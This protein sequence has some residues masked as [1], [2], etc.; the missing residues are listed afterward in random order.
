MVEQG[1]LEITS[2][3][4]VAVARFRSASITDLEEISAVS[5]RIRDFIDKNRP[6]RMVFDFEC[7]KFFSSQV[8]GLI[9]DVRARLKAYSG[10]VVI[11]AIDPQLH[12]VFRITNLDRIL[13]FFPDSESAV[14]SM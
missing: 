5:E 8:L 4:G 12:R 13:K 6:G 1:C 3:Q 7:V 9:M 11:S 2:E 10:E 14:K